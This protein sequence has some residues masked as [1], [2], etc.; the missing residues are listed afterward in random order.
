MLCWTETNCFILVLSLT[1]LTRTHQVRFESVI[2]IWDNNNVM[3]PYIRADNKE[4][5]VTPGTRPP[6]KTVT[7]WQL[8]LIGRNRGLVGLPKNGSKHVRLMRHQNDHHNR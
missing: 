5:N 7:S 2:Y 4:E 6:G 8:L 1:V 3:I